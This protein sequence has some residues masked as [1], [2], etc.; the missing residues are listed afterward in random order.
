M[1]ANCH[2]YLDEDHNHNDYDY[3]YLYVDDGNQNDDNAVWESNS[4]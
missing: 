2:D 3:D 1:V 4:S